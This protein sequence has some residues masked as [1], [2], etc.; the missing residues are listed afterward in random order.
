MSLGLRLIAKLHS[1]ALSQ[2]AL[3]NR[4][5][6]WIRHLYSEMLPKVRLGQVELAPALFCGLHPAAEEIE[7]A[8]VDSEHIVVSAN[9]TTAGPGYHMF[10]TGLL[11]DLAREL[12]ASWNAEENSSD[13]YSDETDYFF[14]GDS[15][16]LHQH[17]NWWLQ[18]LA[19]TFF[20][21]TF[22]SDSR[23]I[24]LCMPMNPHFETEQ[25]ALTPT[26]PRSW[27]WLQKTA[28]DG[29]KGNDFFAWPTAGFNAEYY[30]GRALV[31]M[32]T[33]VRWRAPIND[34]E[35]SHARDVAYCLDC[36]FRLDSSLP[37]PWAEWRE[38]LGFLGEV[39]DE[40]I[41]LPLMAP[42]V[43]P[44]GY[45]RKDVGVTLPGGWRMTVPG[46]FADFEPDNDGDLC[47]V[48]PPREIWFTA[49]RRPANLSV[50][51]F[52]GARNEVKKSHPDHLID[53]EDYFATAKNT[54]KATATT[55]TYFVL[56]SSC[57]TT[58]SR[59]VCT[60]VFSDPKQTDWALKAW[61]SIQ[62]PPTRTS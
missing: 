26:G 14:T 28:Q 33:D 5:E 8:L 20:D 12:H 41:A 51:H 18:A 39:P 57:E 22:D 54:R 25:P 29:S 6:Q 45:R 7:I 56:N 61:Q 37:F 48:D 44:I 23:G 35:R 32:W 2:D 58:S 49:Y 52:E 1:P 53:L 43:E 46:S 27:D 13:E 40:K 55:K 21:G 3:F 11:Q 24:A 42:E 62:P 10:L 31:Q 9:T 38:I 36:A 59:A 30:L 47:A 17:M 4:I 60:I 50:D 16:M 19:G 15:K 34:S